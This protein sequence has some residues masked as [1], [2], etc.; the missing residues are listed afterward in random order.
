MDL[1]LDQLSRSEEYRYHMKS[2]EVRFLRRDL[3]FY[4]ALADH[5]APLSFLPRIFCS[6]ELKR[7]WVK[8]RNDLNAIDHQYGAP[9][10]PNVTKNTKIVIDDDDSLFN[11]FIIV[12]EFDE[13]GYP[14]VEEDDGEPY[15]YYK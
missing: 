10:M 3:E 2:R 15:E 8:K 5:E 12:N 9:L 1:I 13:N 11:D 14:V 6:G 4:N 7:Q